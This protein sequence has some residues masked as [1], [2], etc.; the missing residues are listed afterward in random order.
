MAVWGEGE[1]AEMRG[2]GGGK[3]RRG[4]REEGEGIERKREREKKNN[5]FFLKSLVSF[6]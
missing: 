3:G 5:K 6:F 4:K 1:M 2:V